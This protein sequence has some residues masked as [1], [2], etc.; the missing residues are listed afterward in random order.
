VAEAGGQ[1]LGADV[2]ARGVEQL[3][4]DEVLDPAGAFLEGA[5]VVPG[6]DERSL[7]QGEVG[8]GRIRKAR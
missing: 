1:S 3:K 6:R 7:G 8:A 4:G 2:L 5:V